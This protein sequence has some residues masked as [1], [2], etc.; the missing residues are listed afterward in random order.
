MSATI[1][2]PQ[3]RPLSTNASGVL[4]GQ[5]ISAKAVSYDGG[6]CDALLISLATGEKFLLKKGYSQRNDT[7]MQV[8]QIQ[9]FNLDVNLVPTVAASANFYFSF[10]DVLPTLGPQNLQFSNNGVSYANPVPAAAGMVNGNQGTLR[11]G[12][13]VPLTVTSGGAA[14]ALASSA[15]SGSFIVSNILGTVLRGSVPG[16]SGGVAALRAIRA[17]VSFNVTDAAGVSV[18]QLVMLPMAS[19]AFANIQN[20]SFAALPAATGSYWLTMASVGTTLVASLYLLSGGVPPAIPLSTIT[21]ASAFPAED[22]AISLKVLSG[23]DIILAG[24]G[25]SA[26]LG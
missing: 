17:D 4:I 19:A 21:L 25:A 12:V 16:V 14:Q 7:L 15:L 5:N 24:W 13:V 6:T 1:A 26:V 20:A 3:T 2:N 9:S 11:N 8:T 22:L 23:A 18:I 10:G